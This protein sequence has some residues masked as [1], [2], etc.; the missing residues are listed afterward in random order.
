MKIIIEMTEEEFCNA[1]RFEKPIGPVKKP[2]KK[3]EKAIAIAR[4]L[5]REDVAQKIIHYTNSRKQRTSWDAKLPGWSK[6]VA[7]AYFGTN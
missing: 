6:E 1:V 5:N 3:M 7:D 4:S 2:T